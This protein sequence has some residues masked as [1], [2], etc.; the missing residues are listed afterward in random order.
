MAFNDLELQRKFSALDRF[1][2]V[3]PRLPR[4]GRYARSG[5][6]LLDVFLSLL[7]LPVLLPLLL[8]I[9]LAIRAD[10]GKPV[11]TQPRVGR[12]GK[13]FKCYKFRSMVPDAENVLAAMC[14]QNPEIAREWAMFQKLRCDPRITR[15]GRFLRRTS[16]DELPQIVNVLKGDMSL[17]GP[18]PF[19]PA[20]Q[21]LYDIEGG[22]AYYRLRP[23]IT[24]LW[25]V[26]GRGDTTFATRVRFDE[27]YGKKLSMRADLALILNTATVVVQRT[28]C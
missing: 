14:A 16:L 7:M 6:R 22:T 20:Q 1:E 21:A 4:A 10:G 26:M 17:V 23:G 19:L 25:Q 18:R 24:G 5:K 12:G 28:G 27:A 13:V 11:F 3:E 8:L 2:F 15:L 9:W